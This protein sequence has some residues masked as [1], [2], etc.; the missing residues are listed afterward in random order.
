[1]AL[2][3]GAPEGTGRAGKSQVSADGLPTSSRGPGPRGGQGGGTHLPRKHLGTVLSFLRRS[4]MRFTF[5]FI[6]MWYSFSPFSAIM[7]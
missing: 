4:L 2:P 5:L 3:R 7:T 6:I 1:M